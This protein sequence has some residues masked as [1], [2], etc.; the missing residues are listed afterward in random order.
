M[1]HAICPRLFVFRRQPCGVGGRVDLSQSPLARSVA[2]GWRVPYVVN[3]YSSA[4]VRRQVSLA[5]TAGGSQ[6]TGAKALGLLFCQQA[7]CLSA[8][9]RQPS[10]ESEDGQRLA[11]RACSV[12]FFR[13][14]IASPESGSPKPKINPS[15]FFV[16][17]NPT[18]LRCNGSF[19]RLRP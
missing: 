15:I 1:K 10:L 4:N 8:E 11:G 7:L 6:A 2:L 5:G 14:I 17:V 19:E 12:Y 9:P 3:L 16:P 18:E 13:K